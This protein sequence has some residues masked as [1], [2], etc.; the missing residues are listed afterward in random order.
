MINLRIAMKSC[1]FSCINYFE[2]IIIKVFCSCN[3]QNS[4]RLWNHCVLRISWIHW[5][6]QLH[7]QKKST[8]LWFFIIIIN[9]NAR[10]SF[11]MLMFMFLILFLFSIFLMLMLM[12]FD[13]FM[14]TFF[15]HTT[16]MTS[17]LCLLADFAHFTTMIKTQNVDGISFTHDSSIC[18]SLFSC[19]NLWISEEDLLHEYLIL[20]R[21]AWQQT[22]DELLLRINI[23]LI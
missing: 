10:I 7:R 3:L 2:L 17:I 15:I 8:T 14:F 19:L 22:D 9:I 13:F 20:F 21:N 6:C 1:F 18:L 16:S 11:S 5:W 4:V 23:F 12:F